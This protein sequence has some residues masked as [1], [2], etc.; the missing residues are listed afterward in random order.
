MRRPFLTTTLLVCL[1]CDG[2]PAESDLSSAATVAPPMECTAT[3]TTSGFTGFFPTTGAATGDTSSEE[4][5][6]ETGSLADS[7]TETGSLDCTAFEECWGSRWKDLYGLDAYD[8]DPSCTEVYWQ[9]CAIEEEPCDRVACGVDC[10]MER[11]LVQW[12]CANVYPECDAYRDEYLRAQFCETE[13]EDRETLCDVGCIE[14]D[15]VQCRRD[16]NL[17]YMQCMEPIDER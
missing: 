5:T 3:G 12:D 2:D 9:F 1:A 17:A 14:V 6:E 11:T 8:T 15:P 7:S 10:Q 4:E 13:F 16:A